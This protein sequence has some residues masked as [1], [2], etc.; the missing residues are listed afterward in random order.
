MLKKALKTQKPKVVAIET[1]MIF[2]PQSAVRG[3]KETLVQTHALLFPC[4]PSS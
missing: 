1:D 4:I 3:I 2:R